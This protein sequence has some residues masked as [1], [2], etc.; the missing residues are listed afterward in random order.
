VLPDLN[1]TAVE[2]ANKHT[3]NYFISTSKAQ[4]LSQPWGKS[5]T[6]SAL[7]ITQDPSHVV[8][9]ACILLLALRIQAPTSSSLYICQYST[10]FHPFQS[11]HMLT[12]SFTVKKSSISTSWS[13]AMSTPA[14]PLPPV[15]S[16]IP[17][18]ACR[19]A[20]GASFAPPSSLTSLDTLHRILTYG[21]D[22]IYK[23]GGID[24][25]TIEKFE[26]VRHF[27]L[28]FHILPACFRNFHFR[29]LSATEP[30]R[31][32]PGGVLGLAWALVAHYP[33]AK[34]LHHNAHVFA[35]NQRH[36]NHPLTQC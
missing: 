24:K 35:E 30:W 22:L 25:R 10:I 20:A 34:C 11:Y 16:L 18:S 31:G 13:S 19:V 3:F 28:Y 9:S 14:S 17:E 21:T 15:V 27:Q 32:T 6:L 33:R 8:L 5:S 36:R 2:S 12:T 4:P 23:C 29:H 7:N 1:P 26:K